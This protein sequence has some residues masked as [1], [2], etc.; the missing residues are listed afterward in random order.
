MTGTT[1]VPAARR[2]P[3]LLGQTVVVI[4]GNSTDVARLDQFFDEL[5]APV[6]HLMVTAG[7]PFYAPLATMDFD[8][9]RRDVDQHLWLTLR[10]ARHAAGK[11]RPGGTLLLISGT[12]G[13]RPA[14]GLS[15]VSTF[16]AGLPALTKSLVLGI[17]PVRVNLIAPGFG[18][19]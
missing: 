4:G 15:I 9:A 16:T 11:V 17:A 1:A 19:P 10:V 18:L 8:A 5:P 3:E 13:R 6:D 12:G 2:A 14:I 7:A